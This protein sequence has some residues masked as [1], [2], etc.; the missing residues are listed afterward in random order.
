MSS[1]ILNDS[2]VMFDSMLANVPP[3]DDVRPTAI[4]RPTTS[5]TAAE[6]GSA[7]GVR[8]RGGQTTGRGRVGRTAG[9]NRGGQTSGQ[10]IGRGG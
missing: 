6:G 9:R 8:G 1:N 3:Q 5:E 7:Y 4:R 10:D 2:S